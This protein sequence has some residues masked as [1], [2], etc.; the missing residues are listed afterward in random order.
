MHPPTGE[1]A[2]VSTTRRGKPFTIGSRYFALAVLFG[3]LDREAIDHLVQ[4]EIRQ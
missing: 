4:R 1:P 3:Y 2:L